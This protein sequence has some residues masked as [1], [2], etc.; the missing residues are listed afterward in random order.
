MLAC[1]KGVYWKEIRNT[2]NIWEGWLKVGVNIK[3]L[4]ENLPRARKEE[5]R[6]CSPV[7]VQTLGEWITTALAFTHSRFKYE[8]SKW[9]GSEHVLTLALLE[10]IGQ[11]FSILKL[12]S[13]F[14][15][16]CSTQKVEEASERKLWVY[17][18][19]DT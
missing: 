15:F 7:K 8:G 11:A 4:Q 2:W 17:N 1:Q 14:N 10:L 6:N 19:M 12:T 18:V 13:V 16:S 3:R 5:V 9:S